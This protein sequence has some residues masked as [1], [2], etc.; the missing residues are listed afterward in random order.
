[1]PMYCLIISRFIYNIF[2]ICFSYVIFCCTWI[3]ASS[4]PTCSNVKIRPLIMYPC[5]LALARTTCF[6]LGIFLRPFFSCFIFHPLCAVRGCFKLRIYA[7]LFTLSIDLLDCVVGFYLLFF[8]TIAGVATSRFPV[9][10]FSTFV[11]NIFSSC[12]LLSKRLF[13]KGKPSAFSPCIRIVSKC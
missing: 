8:R 9:Y 4:S 10:F 6:C 11:R 2:H 12:Y 3:I 5:F 13:E 1:M 7:L